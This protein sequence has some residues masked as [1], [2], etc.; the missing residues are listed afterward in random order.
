LVLL[1][2]ALFST[3]NSWAGGDEDDPVPTASS[4]NDSS[5]S[6]ASKSPAPTEQS[7]SAADLLAHLRQERVE[8]MSELLALEEGYSEL[9]IV[10]GSEPSEVEARLSARLTF[11]QTRLERLDLE[12]A[13]TAKGSTGGEEQ[14]AP[15]GAAPLS[16]S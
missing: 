6:E 7:E 4:A 15:A 8:V 5:Q 2:G 9:E 13:Q 11:L 1:L 14:V 16:S 10:D 12:L 3:G